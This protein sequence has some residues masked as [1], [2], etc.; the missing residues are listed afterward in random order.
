LL[1]LRVGLAL[2]NPLRDLLPRPLLPL[3][4][5]W[6]LSSLCRLLSCLALC[7]GS[8]IPRSLIPRQL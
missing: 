6:L 1:S 3:A 4:P 8:L 5:G 7:P 2:L